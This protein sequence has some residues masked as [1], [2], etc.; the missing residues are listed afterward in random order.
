MGRSGKNQLLE[1]NIKAISSHKNAWKRRKSSRPKEIIE[2]SKRILEEGGINDLSMVKISKAA[3]VSEAT[4]YKYF[5]NKQDLLNQIVNE[6]FE[7]FIEKT[8]KDIQEVTDLYSRLLFLAIRYLEGMK[9]T[10]KIHKLFIKELRWQKYKDSEAHIV[11]KRYSKILKNIIENSIKSGE[12]KES[13][14]FPVFESQFYGGLEHLSLR[15]IMINRTINIGKY[16]SDHVDILYAG[17][18]K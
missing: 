2:A 11:K 4:I 1:S 10:P 18:K 9:A 16:S 14:N 8:E 3:G 13:L 5:D 17:I 12:V 7:P 6:W 15:T